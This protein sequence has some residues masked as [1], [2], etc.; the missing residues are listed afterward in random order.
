MAI[1]FLAAAMFW[2]GAPKLIHMVR[3]SGYEG[4][5]KINLVI[6]TIKLK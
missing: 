1:Q 3:K 2:F 5:T 4:L 6:Y